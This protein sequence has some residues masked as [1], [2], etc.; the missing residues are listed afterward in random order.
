MKEG[1]IALEEALRIARQIA[2]P[3]DAAHDKGIVRRDP[4]PAN[5][6]IKPDG[7]V[8]VLDFRLAKLRPAD[9]AP[10]SKPEESPTFSMAA[11]KAGMILRTAAYMSPE[12]ARGK[13]V[14][15]HA[16]IWAFGVVLHE[17]LTG[18]RLFE[19]ED[20][21]ETLALVLKGGR[22]GMGFQPACSGC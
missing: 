1:A 4:K 12:Q 5:I 17:M 7:T 19:G 3:L 9:P 6:T 2:D 10:G 14:D 15:K 16:D 11:S 8:K 22:S 20:V 21:T 13:V 18:R